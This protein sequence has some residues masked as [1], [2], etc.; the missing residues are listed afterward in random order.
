MRAE[1][2]RQAAT[3]LSQMLQP[4][5]EQ[6][7]VEQRK[8]EL[9][10]FASEHPEIKSDEYRMP[11]AKMLQERPELRLEDAFYIVKAKVDSAV[12]STERAA[13][14]EQR[15]RRKT[16]FGKT[17]SGS[18]STPS[19]VPQFKSAWESYQWHKNNQAK[20]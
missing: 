14:E 9:R 10:H 20:K 2:Q 4:A 3:M 18:A 17:S 8:V 19:G 1:I 6:L 15:Q 11:I 7:Q 12:A 5:Q 13:L 16:A